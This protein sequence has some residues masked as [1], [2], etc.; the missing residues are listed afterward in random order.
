MGNIVMIVVVIVIV[1]VSL[2]GMVDLGGGPSYSEPL[3]K[4]KLLKLV[5]IGFVILLIIGGGYYLYQLPP[6]EVSIKYRDD[7][8][9]VSGENFEHV[10][11]DDSTLKNAWYDRSEQYLILQLGKTNYHYCDTP[12]DAWENLK[13]SSSPYSTYSNLFKGN[14]DCRTGHVPSY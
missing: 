14:Y 11:M 8:V 1:A 13:N 9:N 6:T 4:R 5:G 12:F 10:R 3:D 7:K 2:L